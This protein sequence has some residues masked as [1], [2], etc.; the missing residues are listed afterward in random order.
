M[1]FLPSD[2]SPPTDWVLNQA[3]NLLDTDQK[4]DFKFSLNKNI[5]RIALAILSIPMGLASSAYHGLSLLKLPVVF[6]NYTIGY[7]PVKGKRLGDRLPN[8]FLLKDLA[9]HLYK[10]VAHIIIEPFV[11]LPV[12]IYSPAANVKLHQYLRLTK[13][14]AKKF[15]PPPPPPPISGL[16]KKQNGTVKHIQTV[17]EKS[18]ENEQTSI[19][20]RVKKKPFGY[21]SGLLE[22]LVKMKGKL[23]K[24]EE[25]GERP[26]IKAEDSEYEEFRIKILEK[27][28]ER[29]FGADEDED[30][31]DDDFGPQDGD[32]PKNDQVNETVIHQP[33]AIK[34]NVK[35]DQISTSKPAVIPARLSPE[36][37][38]QLR[39]GQVKL[40]K[41][42]I[43][44]KK[45]VSAYDKAFEIVKNKKSLD[46]SFFEETN[47]DNEE[48]DEWSDDDYIPDT[49]VGVYIIASEQSSEI[50]DTPEEICQ[51]EI[52]KKI[53][54]L[55]RNGADMSLA[56]PHQKRAAAGK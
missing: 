43:T 50:I 20:T 14:K 28:L 3:Q 44:E 18:E 34:K 22:E 36:L 39:D 12:G 30:C 16:L 1:R 33:I 4:S 54:A 51:T 25:R 19:P 41:V 46:Q 13:P 10:A 23:K 26:E 6:L 35:S 5:A 37:L 56:N 21:K 42:E 24:M 31:F 32:L 47:S 29:A 53:A 8:G 15:Q 40:R 52:E 17:P 45:S 38:T 49:D 55:K 7:I 11:G 48:V 2:T 9:L 27:N